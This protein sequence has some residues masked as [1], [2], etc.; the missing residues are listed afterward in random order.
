MN[1]HQ[2]NFFMTP[3]DLL[4]CERRIQENGPVVFFEYCSTERTPHVI[5]NS[6]IVEMG[7]ERLSIGLARPQDLSLIR[8][9]SVEGQSYFTLD[10]L[11]SPAIELNR[12]Y[13]DGNHLRR[14]RLY[15]TVKSYDESGALIEK[16]TEFLLWAQALLKTAKAGLA[17][18][19]QLHSY[20]GAD[21]ESIR[22]TTKC[23]F[24][25]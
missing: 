15:F 25:V 16:N 7:K 19:P 14:G 12:C 11:R 17:L 13:F 10:I 2:V 8:F 22:K 23:Q 24:V 21:A 9:K 18:D 6:K 3:L 1:S 5:K 20:V 4:E